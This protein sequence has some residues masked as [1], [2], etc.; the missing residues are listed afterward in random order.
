[1]DGSREGVKHSAPFFDTDLANM[2]SSDSSEEDSQDKGSVKR[3]QA[4]LLESVDSLNSDKL[5]AR[6]TDILDNSNR[7]ST[8]SSASVEPE[9]PEQAQLPNDRLPSVCCRRHAACSAS[10]CV[11]R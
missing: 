7:T 10:V 3:I 5:A 2:S 11:Y 9:G 4:A 1:M 8:A 6:E